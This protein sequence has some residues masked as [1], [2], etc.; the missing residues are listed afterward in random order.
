M[1]KTILHIIA[2]IAQFCSFVCL[3]LALIPIVYPVVLILAAIIVMMGLLV[4]FLYPVRRRHDA[5]TL[6]QQMEAMAVDIVE[7]IAP[8]RLR[9]ARKALST[10]AATTDNQAQSTGDLPDSES[11]AQL[12]MRQWM[13][14]HYTTRI[15]WRAVRLSIVSVVLCLVLFVGL[16]LH[17][18][19]YYIN[20]LDSELEPYREAFRRE[21][22]ESEG[23][24]DQEMQLQYD[25]AGSESR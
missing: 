25:P 20:T 6:A 24:P 12:S 18:N 8:G 16:R 2:Q 5:L 13:H 3:A 22:P 10:P 23:P 9:R 15:A 21:R 7:E 1:K 19:F 17:S 11:A 14:G 4:L